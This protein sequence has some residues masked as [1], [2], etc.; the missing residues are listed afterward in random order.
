MRRSGLVVCIYTRY[1]VP[2][3]DYT[4]GKHQRYIFPIPAYYLFLC[5][6]WMVMWCWWRC[7]NA[8]WRKPFMITDPQNCFPSP[9]H[10]RLLRISSLRPPCVNLGY[11][12][13]VDPGSLPFP[14]CWSWLPFSCADH[15]CRWRWRCSNVAWNKM[16]SLPDGI[17]EW[18]ENLKEV[19][20]DVAE[21]DSIRYVQ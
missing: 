15:G 21:S 7:R 8:P 1:Q 11:P 14:V 9:A 5:R 4:I 19:W 18:L 3:I 12:S 17:F 6:C 10:N 2:G 16:T 13:Y 20:V